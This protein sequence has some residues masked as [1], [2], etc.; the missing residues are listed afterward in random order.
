MKKSNKSK[1]DSEQEL[2]RAM[3]ANYDAGVRHAVQQCERMCL[4]LYA[5]SDS[6]KKAE[7]YWFA[8]WCIKNETA[9]LLTQ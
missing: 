6:V 4:H 1:K 9:D 5:N 8:A 2:A 3:K 7:A